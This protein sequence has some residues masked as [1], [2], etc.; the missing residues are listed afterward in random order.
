MAL[1]T[2]YS[3][4]L[5][6]TVGEPDAEAQALWELRD[7]IYNTCG[8]Y[9]SEQRRFFLESRCRRRMNALGM[10]SY[11]DYL[12]LVR[13]P[14]QRRGELQL[15][16]DEIT[17]NETSFFR[18]QA[19]FEALKH[20]FLP[21]IARRKGR[22]GFRRLKIWSAGC[23]SGEEPYSLAI[24]VHELASTILA[25]WQ[26]EIVA[27]DINHAVLEKARKGLYTPYSFRNT[28][29]EIINRYFQKLDHEA[30]Q[31]SPQIMQMVQFRHMNL[32][33]DMAMLFMKGYDIIFCRNVLIYFDLPAKKR[34]TQHFYNA[35]LD[36]GYLFVGHSESLFGVNDQFK[37]VQ[38]PG[39]LAYKKGKNEG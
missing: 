17:V 23:S 28:P 39:G 33:D 10:H 30:Y 13:D 27:T 3:I 37:M 31:L 2:G 8:M 21:E 1:P 36:E 11:Q 14:R 20:I 22:I 18:N 38:Y 35:L 6:S 26:V 5:T 32:M 29:P 7:L 9:F 24:V 16:L 34:V 4:P 25:G 19:Q 15:L 12:Q